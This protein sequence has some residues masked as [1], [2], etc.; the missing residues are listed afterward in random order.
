MK[1]LL[2]GI[3]LLLIFT[4]QV[5]AISPSPTLAPSPSISS[6]QKNES[7]VDQINELKDKIASRVA[8]LK[9]VERRGIIGT[10]TDVNDSH[11]SLTNAKGDIKLVDVDEITKFSS[12]TQKG[13]FGISDVK[14]GMTISVIGLFN[15]ESKHTIARFVS[16]YTIPTF[17]GGTV[18]D[19]N[20]ADYTITIAG[21]DNINVTID[22]ETTT[23]IN[24]YSEGE[25]TRSGFTKMVA[26]DRVQIVGSPNK[27]DK[28]RITASSI[29]VLNDLFSV[30]S[31]TPTP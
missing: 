23:S 10:V 7:L 5:L 20:K 14:R 4:P 26:G 15:K 8:Q 29:L 11:I 27:T 28:T 21:K 12:S 24:S 3:L 30:E 31:V 9:L 22:I 13:T 16:T 17:I 1:Y 19:V 18:S 25:I 6:S 2:T